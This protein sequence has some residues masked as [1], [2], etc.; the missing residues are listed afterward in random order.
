MNKSLISLRKRVF[1]RLQAFDKITLISN[2]IIWGGEYEKILNF[3]PRSFCIPPCIA[4]ERKFH[5]QCNRGYKLRRF[6]NLQ[7][8]PWTLLSWVLKVC[9]WQESHTRQSGQHGG[10]R[11]MPW[12]WRS[13]CWKRR[14]KG[15]RHT[16]L[17][18]KNR[19]TCQRFQVSCMPWG[20]KGYALL[21]SEQT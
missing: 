14:R 3:F 10:M 18:Q 6:R 4:S 8:V 2:K 13:T 1:K 19:C 20:F 16:C 9:S 17:W 7:R 11:V 21:E 15:R 5:R 12:P